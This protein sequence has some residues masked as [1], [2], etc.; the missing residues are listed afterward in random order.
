MNLSGLEIGRF[1]AAPLAG[2]SDVAQRV[3]CE[4][5]GADATVT[6]MVSAKGLLMCGEATQALLNTTGLTKPKGVQLFGA[7]PFVMKEAVGLPQLQKFDFIDLNMGCPVPKVTKTGAGSALMKNVDR[8]ATLVRV[9]TEGTKKPVTVKFRLGFDSENYLEFGKVCQ[10][11]G[12]SAVTLHARTRA[13][14]YSGQADWR[15]IARLREVLSIPVIANGDITDGPS[16]Q[17]CVQETQCQGYMIGRAAMGR[18]WIF[19]ELKGQSVE[20]DVRAIIKEHYALL[21][22]NYDEH[23]AVV[24]MRHMLGCYLRGIPGASKARGELNSAKTVEQVFE[25]IDRVF[26]TAA[27]ND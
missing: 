23:Y 14:G 24:T 26:G 25:V 16:Y 22:A 2:V 15:A 11:A 7:D 13:Q 5:F 12:A 10:D 19:A 3:L 9:A 21:M 4:R 27:D 18:P 8:A 6:E 20:I 1:F 17:A